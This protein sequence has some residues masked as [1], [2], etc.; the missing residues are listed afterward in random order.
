MRWQIFQSQTRSPYYYYNNN[1]LL[2]FYTL[3]CIV[4]KVKSQKV[5]IKAGVAVGPGRRQS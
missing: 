2:F 5:K 1:L 3:G 4:P